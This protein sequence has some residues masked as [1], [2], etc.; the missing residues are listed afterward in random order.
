M[1][2]MKLEAFGS[3]WTPSKARGLI[4]PQ[5]AYAIASLDGGGLAVALGVGC[6]TGFDSS[7]NEITGIA[8][9]NAA[10]YLSQ[11]NAAPHMR[12]KEAISHAQARLVANYW[13]NDG[14][15]FDGEEGSTLICAL[16]KENR[17]YIGWIGSDEAFLV[18]GDKIINRTEGHTM[19]KEQY[20]V[21]N[22]FMQKFGRHVSSRGLT[23]KPLD[24]KCEL[25]IEFNS[26]A[27][28]LMAGDLIVFASHHLLNNIEVEDIPRLVK[29]K[30][31]DQAVKGLIDTTKGKELDRQ[32]GVGAVVV[33]VMP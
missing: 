23:S 21:W 28:L 25:A 32:W 11:S 29:D 10:A 1:E 18:R 6:F 4:N 31:P 3:V 30:T 19:Y 7:F 13:K 15:I 26:E 8:V 33:Q 5:D 2:A 9:R 27:W 14:E 17:A 22:S 24:D 16:V 20:Q 12:I